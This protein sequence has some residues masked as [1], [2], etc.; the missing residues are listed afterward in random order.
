MAKLLKLRRGTTTQHGSFTGAEGEVTIDTDKDTAVVHDGSTA[1][2]TP[3][4]KEDMSNVSSSS[5]AGRLGADSIATSKIAAGA[6]PTD[7]TVASAN[8]VDGTIVNA[9][10]N[11]SAAIAN[12]KLADSGVTA[13]SVGSSTA[14]P[15]I[16][17]N[18]KGIV[19]GTNTTSIDSTRIDNGTSNV[20]VTN[21]GNILV[22]RTGTDRLTIN[23]SGIDV[24]GNIVV[25]GT[26][27]GRDV[28]ADGSKLDNIESGA[29]A[30]QTKADIDGLNINADQLD[31]QHGSYYQNASNLN[32]GTVSA[33][34]L[35]TA[36]TQSAGNDS[37][38][39]ATT[40]FVQ[41]AVAN[42]VDS[43]P[44]TLDTLNELAAALGDDANFASTT[45]TSIG[46]KLSK[47]G[48]EMTGNI[49]MSGSQT[50]DGRDLSV[51]GAKLDG[52]AANANNYSF[53][54]TVSDAASNG[55]VVQRHS[56]G[57]IFAN[58]FNSTDNS[59][60]SGV[61]GLMCKE[62]NNGDY[63]RTATAG[64]VR[65]FLNV[66]DG[67]TGDQ[68][69]SEIASALNGQN[70]YTT[71]NIG[72]DSNDAFVFTN[73]SQVDLYIN[74]NNEFRFESDGDF[75]ADGDVIAYSTTTASDENLKKDITIVTDAVTK[76]EALKGVTF[77]WKKDDRKS[78]GL[79]AQDVEKVLPDAVRKVAN[80]EGD[81]FLAVNY[82]AVMS[83]LVESVKELSA[84]V[85]ELEAK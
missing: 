66:E 63:L 53:P 38:K 41:T 32:A 31:G 11:A 16:T 67:A 43:A 9:D 17:V 24:N 85:K 2:G 55:T 56:S 20:R 83:I 14:I 75:H 10:I 28:A 6:L 52:I 71:G 18:A 35:D 82:G 48:G 78:A 42:V 57:Y 77:T 44:G 76:C 13:G 64:A 22:S 81:E 50:V 29:T 5:I 21:V 54:Y 80:L 7:V 59:V 60:S 33:S 47:S 26:V 3:L 73:N 8:I 40:A 39:I 36:T 49:T 68:S 19:T 1:G 37:T 34:R 69:G 45:A 27:D 4:A 84:R 15:I 79:I 12:S 62:T 23:N 72:R 25:S 70:I 30:D 65:S 46:T 74:G 51:D 61:S 58:Y